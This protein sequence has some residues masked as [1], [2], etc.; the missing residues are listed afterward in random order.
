MI[1]LIVHSNIDHSIKEKLIDDL[2][3]NSL[4]KL[5]FF[6]ELNEI[7]VDS[8]DSNSEYLLIMLKDS[9]L[10]DIVPFIKHQGKGPGVGLEYCS[11]LE[12]C[13]VWL[14]KDHQVLSHK[15][16]PNEPIDGYILNGLFKFNIDSLEAYLKN[17]LDAL[18]EDE[19]WGMPYG[20]RPALKMESFDIK[21]KRALF[22]DRDGIIVA[23]HGYVS[24]LKETQFFSGILPLIKWAN[25]NDWFV[26]VLTNQ[27]GV[28]RGYFTENDVINF[29]Q[30]LNSLIESEGGKIDDW[31]HCPYHETKGESGYKRA[32]LLRKPNPGMA[33]LASEWHSIEY[34]K[35]IMIG[36][37]ISDALSLPGLVNL[38]L[39]GNYDLTNATNPVFATHE[40]IMAYILNNLSE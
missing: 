3:K 16:V 24:K 32:S 9:L 22:L 26:F 30:E 34:E 8:L 38:H 20:K 17:G 12:K 33:L 21:K 2:K 23:D 25:N 10:P 14:G 13:S 15:N 39:K 31:I 36:D 37:K 35:S 29:H 19:I 28:A 6:N 27:A 7:K 11:D 5:F 4:E 1:P 18:W 40:E